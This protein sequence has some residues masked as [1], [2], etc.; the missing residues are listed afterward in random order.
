MSKSR[1]ITD[2]LKSE[3]EKKGHKLSHV[4]CNSGDVGIKNILTLYLTS[5]SSYLGGG[6]LFTLSSRGVGGGGEGAY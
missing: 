5:T 6:G 4:K 2:I 1:A 3:L